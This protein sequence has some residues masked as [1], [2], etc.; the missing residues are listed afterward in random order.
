[1]QPHVPTSVALAQLLSEAPL[2]VSLAWSAAPIRTVP[3]F[4]RPSR[5]PE[6]SHSSSATLGTWLSGS[7]I[8]TS[9]PKVGHSIGA[10][11]FGRCS[12]KALRNAGRLGDR[13]TLWRTSPRIQG[14]GP[15]QDESRDKRSRIG[16][17]YDPRE[18]QSRKKRWHDDRR[19]KPTHY[20][21]SAFSSSSRYSF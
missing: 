20:P 6:I 12:P 16:L 2:D 1:M 7:T 13:R 19:N 15:G 8:A 9:D 18:K 14:F 17:V 10:Q 3:E 4:S 21:R 5:S 11:E